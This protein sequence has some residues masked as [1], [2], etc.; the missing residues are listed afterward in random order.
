MYDEERAYET[1]KLRVPSFTCGLA[2]NC[3]SKASNWTSPASSP[4]KYVLL[5]NVSLHDYPVHDS[6]L[7]VVSNGVVH[8]RPVV[9]KH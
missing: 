6:L 4:S 2:S 1:K 8:H 7:V 3:A 5:W 9:P